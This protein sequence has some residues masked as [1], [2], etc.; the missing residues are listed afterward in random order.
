VP[1]TCSECVID[2]QTDGQTMEISINRCY[3]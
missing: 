2:R 3:L 1:I